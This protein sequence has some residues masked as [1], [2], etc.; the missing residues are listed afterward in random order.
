MPD[1]SLRLNKDML[2][3][4]PLFTRKLL[5]SQ[6]HADDCLE[7]YNILDDE[8]VREAHLRYRHAGAQCTPTNTLDA[9]R[10]G[11]QE[12]GLE[13]ALVDLNR[14]GV[15]LAREAG[16]EHVLATVRLAAEDVV[17]EQVAALLLEK[18][19]AIWLIGSDEEHE[20]IIAGIRELTDIPI[21]TPVVEA[22]LEGQSADILCLMGEGR[23]KSLASLG[24]LGGQTKAALMVCPLLSEPQYTT[25][26]QRRDA[27]GTRADEMADFALEARLLGA[28]FIGT[29]AGSSPVLT[30][31]AAATLLGL[32]VA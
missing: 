8:L 17:L 23:E 25:E 22:F 26:R 3:V 18:P 2:V 19:D 7:Y 15:R 1:L 21:I 14:L 13:A 16:F 10:S 28:Q 27:L 6:M 32:D 9:N 12:H 29:A 31:V 24:K 5:D 30:G 4:A 11:L 20:A